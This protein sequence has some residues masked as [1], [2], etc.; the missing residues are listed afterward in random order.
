MPGYTLT[1]LAIATV[2]PVHLLDSAQ[3]EQAAGL[4]IFSCHVVDARVDFSLHCCVHEHGDRP[5]ALLEF[6]DRHLPMTG[7]VTGYALDEQ[8]L[9]SLLQ[10]PGSASSPALA[11]LAGTRP[12]VVINLRGINEDGEIV[13]LPDA[14]AQIGVPA[15]RRDADDRFIDFTFSRTAPVF[16]ALQTD[17]IAA[18]QLVLRQIATRTALGHEVEARLRPALELWLAASDL[19]A[20]QIHR[21]CAA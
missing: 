5:A 15:S 8:I 4:A 18:M 9:P 19:P 7:I 13:S 3:R 2:N 10:L 1:A 11:M 14:C 16:H 21:S 20:A 12:R 6:L 17:V